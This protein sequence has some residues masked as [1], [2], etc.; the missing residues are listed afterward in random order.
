MRFVGLTSFVEESKNSLNSELDMIRFLSDS[1]SWSALKHRQTMKRRPSVH[2]WTAAGGSTALQ[3]RQ[4]LF[5]IEETA[6]K[7]QQQQKQQQEA[8]D[9]R[10]VFGGGSRCVST[11]LGVALTSAG[12][13]RGQVDLIVRALL[14][15]LAA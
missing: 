14:S 2:L 5:R 9:S 8:K 15:V 11:A 7:Q 6:D 12:D 1:E 10:I 4:P 13:S 3:C